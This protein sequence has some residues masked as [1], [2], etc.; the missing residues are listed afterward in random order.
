MRGVFEALAAQQAAAAA[1]PP[2]GADLWVENLSYHPP[3]APA[4]LL[5]GAALALP[6]NSLGLVLGASGAG[7]STLL[8]VLAGL[9]EATAGA[10]RFGGAAG[11]AL[12]ARARAA[13]AGLVFQFPERHFVGGTLGEE[14]TLGWPPG[15]SERAARSARAAAAL[16]ALGLSDVPLAAPLSSLSGGYKRRAALAVQLARRPRLLL[17]DEPLA[18]LDWR[19]RGELVRALAALK[20]ECT[21]LVVSHDVRELAPLADAVWRMAPGGALERSSG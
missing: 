11:E 5:A 14:L 2:A 3:G 19:A 12:P 16:A 18:G 1:P 6:P 20:R 8:H 10:V 13:A 4:P 21:L 15:A 17:L 7:K 9:A